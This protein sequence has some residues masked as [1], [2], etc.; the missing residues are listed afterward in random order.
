MNP[1]NISQANTVPGALGGT[2]SQQ[3]MR[4]WAV[5]LLDAIGA[6]TADRGYFDAPLT[7]RAKAVRG[8]LRPLPSALQD[9][10]NGFDALPQAQAAV[11]KLHADV[12]LSRAAKTARTGPL[13]TQ[14]GDACEQA[15]AAMQSALEMAATALQKA[16]LP[17]RPS[18]VDSV[19]AE[20]AANRLE[21]LLPSEPQAFMTAVRRLL[22]QAAQENDELTVWLLA[23]FDTPLKNVFRAID[24]SRVRMAESDFHQ[25][26]MQS[27]TVATGRDADDLPENIGAILRMCQGGGPGTFQGV[28]AVALNELYQWKRSMASWVA[29]I[30]PSAPLGPNGLP[31]SGNYRG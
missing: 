11:A 19:T 10:L 27:L 18:G 23:G 3:A 14:A 6:A 21:R 29:S 17:Q 28:L 22:E 12:Q 24:W 16:L 26:L 15:I 9:L 4:A 13:L 8:A 7:T 1:R 2:P 5:Q 30:Q 25:Q 31:P 20:S